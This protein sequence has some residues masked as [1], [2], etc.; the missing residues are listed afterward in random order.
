MFFDRDYYSNFENR[1]TAYAPTMCSNIVEHMPKKSDF[2]RHG[3]CSHK[4]LETSKKERRNGIL[5]SLRHAVIAF[6]V[7]VGEI[8]GNIL[9][10][11]T[12]FDKLGEIIETSVQRFFYKVSSPLLLF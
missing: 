4:T 2:S 10:L 7:S 12:H 11:E 9:V 3:I 6:L 8:D 1:S 5:A